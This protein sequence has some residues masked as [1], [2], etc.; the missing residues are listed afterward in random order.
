MKWVLSFPELL[1]R[2]RRFSGT[3]TRLYPGLWVSPSSSFPSAWPSTGAVS[4]WQ[5]LHLD[6][7]SSTPS[8]HTR[9]CDSSSM[10]CRYSTSLLPGCAHCCKLMCVHASAPII[11]IN[12][13]RFLC[14]AMEIIHS[15][16]SYITLVMDRLDFLSSSSLMSQNIHVWNNRHI[17]T[18][19]AE[20]QI[21]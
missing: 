18:R 3:S 1:V 13:H 21:L 16:I 15:Y 20:R 2:H 7:S 9:N 12:S 19:L 17:T 8:C 14:L 10:S 11:G 4:Y 5:L 6:L